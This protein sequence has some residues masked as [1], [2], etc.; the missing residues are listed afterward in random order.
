MKKWQWLSIAAVF[1]LAIGCQKEPETLI[2]QTQHLEEGYYWSGSFDAEADVELDVEMTVTTGSAVD[3]LLMDQTGFTQFQNIFK[4][5]SFAGNDNLAPEYYVAYGLNVLNGEHITYTFSSDLTADIYLVD[6]ANYIL[7]QNGQTFNYYAAYEGITY[8]QFTFT[9]VASESLYYIVDNSTYWGTPPQGT[10]AYSY[11]ATK[12]KGTT[13]TYYNAGSALKVKDKTYS[14]TTP[15]AGKYYVVIN[16]AGGI[17]N[18]AT[19]TGPVDVDIL[20]TAK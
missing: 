9:A 15:D 5:D 8:S 16:N 10:I 17:Q 3:V 7:Y 4:V 19:P 14:F 1:L 2:D 12:P 13:F 6:P 18:G 20:I 11:L